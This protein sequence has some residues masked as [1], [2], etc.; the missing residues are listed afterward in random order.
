MTMV[1]DR[2]DADSYLCS[3]MNQ[4]ILDYLTMEGYSNAAAT[5]A[6]EAGIDSLK[7]NINIEARQAIRH[8][9]LSAKLAEAII[10]LN[11][12]DVEVRFIS[13][14]PITLHILMIRTSFYMHHSDLS[15][16]R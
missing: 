16:E 4:I 8:Y 6:R 11:D 15:F 13:L 7:S 3:H 9:I 10:A 5:F 1:P 14:L 2:T 12:L